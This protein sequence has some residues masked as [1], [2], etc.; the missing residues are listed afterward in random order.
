M[1][2]ASANTNAHHAAQS[3][4]ADQ[5]L[6]SIKSLRE[7]EKAAA[8]KVEEAKQEAARIEAAAREKAVEISAK[9]SE[10]AVQAK[11]ELRLDGRTK[12]DKEVKDIIS[13]AQKQASK[14]R[15]RRLSEKDAQAIAER[16]F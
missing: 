13:E 9:A 10:K 14:I 11:N 2:N 6:S 16:I 4:Y 3:D 7:A 5:F 1:T 12:S 8:G 15:T